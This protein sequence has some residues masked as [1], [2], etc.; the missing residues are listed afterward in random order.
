MLDQMIAIVQEYRAYALTAFVITVFATPVAAR[1]ARRLGV[2]DVPDQLLKPH[3]RPTPYLGGTAICLGWAVAAL[4]ALAFPPDDATIDWRLLVPIVAG[5]V[6]VSVIGLIDDMRELPPK[7][8]LLAGTAVIVAVILVTGVGAKL[9]ESLLTPLG[10]DLPPGVRYALAVL[11]GVFIVLGACNSANLIDGL[12]GLC[13]GVTAIISLGFCLLAAHL[14]SLGHSPTGDPVR[15][16]LALAMLGATTGFLPLNFNPAKIFM[17]DAGS[18]LLGYNCGMMI[19]LF[20]ERGTFRWVIGALMIF[21][22]PIF[23]TALAMFRRWRSGR[24]IFAGDRS[25]FYD[26]LVQR[27]LTVRQ[28]VLVSYSLTVFF[29]LVGLLVIWIR[30]RYAVIAYVGICAV[31]AVVAWATGLTHPDKNG[32]ATDASPPL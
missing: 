21:A 25:H 24:P 14:A 32:R 17:G 31:A 4:A 27:G 7:F 22:L 23:D 3:A 28:S 16:V 8:R 29:G 1:V 13:T 18:T 30:T 15:L 5:G 12:D 6:L 2:M 20:A 9:P 11:I 19:L 10:I 26:Q